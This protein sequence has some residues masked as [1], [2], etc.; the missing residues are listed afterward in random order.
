MNVQEIEIW[1]I[2]VKHQRNEDNWLIV[3]KDDDGIEH[4]IQVNEANI[5]EDIELGRHYYASGNALCEQNGISTIF[6]DYLDQWGRYCSHCGKHHEEGY[7]VYEYYYACSRECAISLCGSE[8]EFI[9]SF[10]LDED[11]TCWTEWYN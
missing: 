2:C 10:A 9:G 7:W 11:A 1:G 6:A 5:H 3:L 8:E 4:N